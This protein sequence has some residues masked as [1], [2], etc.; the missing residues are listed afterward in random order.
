MGNLIATKR[1]ASKYLDVA[2]EAG[3]LEEFLIG[4]PLFKL[5]VKDSYGNDVFSS[6]HVMEA[7]YDKYREDPNCNIDKMTH[8]SIINILETT[9]HGSSILN[10]FDDIVYQMNAQKNKTAPFSFDCGELLESMKK[11]LIKNERF[12]KYPINNN[13][14]NGIWPEIEMYDVRIQQTLGRK[15]L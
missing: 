7:I 1:L 14:P 12:Y 3:C 2:L 13:K 6:M 9:R 4:F 10:L 15:L 11:N 5:T 8:D